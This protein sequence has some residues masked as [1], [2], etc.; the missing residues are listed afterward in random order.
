M[1]ARFLADAGAA[2]MRSSRKRR[3]FVGA[4]ILF[5]HREP[6]LGWQ[7][8]LFRRSIEPDRGAWSVVGGRQEP[9]ETMEQTA[10]READEEAFNWHLG[11]RPGRASLLEERLAS[12]L[13]AGFAINA[14]RSSTIWLP[15]AFHYRTFLVELTQ[16]PPVGAFT[17]DPH[18]CD[19]CRW[20]PAAQLP[21][22]VH[23]FLPRTVRQLGLH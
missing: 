12:F 13:P 19:A 5:G 14:C 7:V 11:P 3:P 4:G 10:L 8:L 1:T 6:S 9:D 17:P 2:L 18:E 22:D 23:R 15:A 16:E 21:V 20:F